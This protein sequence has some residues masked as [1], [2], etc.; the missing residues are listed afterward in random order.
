MT[1]S[2]SSFASFS[3]IRVQHEV[4]LGCELDL[5]QSGPPP[6][7]FQ[8]LVALW[9]VLQSRL[10]LVIHSPRKDRDKSVLVLQAGC[11][12]LRPSQLWVAIHMQ[13]P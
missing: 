11:S 1:S 3:A 10:Q 7:S 4:A 5:V 8:E 13:L 6:P 12:S 2:E 9:P